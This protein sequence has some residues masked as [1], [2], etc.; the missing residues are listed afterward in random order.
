MMQRTAPKRASVKS[1]S[2][3]RMHLA[4]PR[5]STPNAGPENSCSSCHGLPLACRP[6]TLCGVAM[7]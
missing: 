6:S 5:Q 7:P 1:V 4:W 3:L 2:D